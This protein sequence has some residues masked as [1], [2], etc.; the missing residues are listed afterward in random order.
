MQ[1]HSEQK[2]LYITNK[3]YSAQFRRVPVLL[4]NVQLVV[5][6]AWKHDW[7]ISKLHTRHFWSMSL[8]VSAFLISA[9]LIQKWSKTV[10]NISSN[11]IRFRA[12][13]IF[14]L[15]FF[16][17]CLYSGLSL[18]LWWSLLCLDNIWIFRSCIHNSLPLLVPQLQNT[19][20]QIKYHPWFP[21]RL[22]ESKHGHC[23]LSGLDESDPVLVSVCWSHN[24][25][26]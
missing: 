5:H 23:W 1:P 9:S 11:L 6:E 14:K 25:S 2:S 8:I 7:V 19:L 16:L 12:A 21:D 13:L 15:P 18:S 24:H 20:L 4:V 26:P 10:A 22:A 17:C 3:M